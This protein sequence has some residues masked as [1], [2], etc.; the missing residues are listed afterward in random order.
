[1]VHGVEKKGDTS[2]T[3]FAYSFMSH[4]SYIVYCPA[5]HSSTFTEGLK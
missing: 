2:E 1:M 4:L 3:I 5:R